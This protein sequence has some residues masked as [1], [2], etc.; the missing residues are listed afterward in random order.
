M[1]FLQNFDSSNNNDCSRHGG[2]CALAAICHRFGA[3]LQS[4]LPDLY[5]RTVTDIEQ[6]NDGLVFSYLKS[7]K[8]KFF[9]HF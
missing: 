1:I 5:N 3:E 9:S 2:E 6:F 7:R 4:K 8:G